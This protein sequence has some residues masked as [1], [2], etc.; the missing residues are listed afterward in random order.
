MH[1]VLSPPP[2]FVL[3]NEL[4]YECLE[5]EDVA[6]LHFLE[7]SDITYSVIKPQHLTPY[8]LPPSPYTLRHSP[9]TYTRYI[10]HPTPYTL[11]PEPYTVPPQ[12]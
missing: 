7:S 3:E 10:L 11:H 2:L 5:L 9:Y 1:H 4:P 8:P 6:T 12:P